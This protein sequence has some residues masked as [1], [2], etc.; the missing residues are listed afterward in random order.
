MNRWDWNALAIFIFMVFMTIVAIKDDYAST[1]GMIV[2]TVAL[3]GMLFC[4]RMSN[5][6]D[7]EINR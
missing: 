6:H 4:W 1:A 7:E 3:V 5:R 2:M